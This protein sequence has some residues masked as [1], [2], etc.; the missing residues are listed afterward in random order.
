MRLHL[1]YWLNLLI[2]LS[3]LFFLG[4]LFYF[5]V[6]HT[7]LGAHPNAWALGVLLSSC[8]IL[9]SLIG[10]YYQL[11]RQLALWGNMK[12]LLR[13]TLLFMLITVNLLPT[14]TFVLLLLSFSCLVLLWR[15]LLYC[16][17]V[18]Y[19]KRGYNLRSFAIVGYSREG[20]YLANYFSS[21]SDLGYV[22]KGYFDIDIN[23]PVRGNVHDLLSYIQRQHLNVIYWCLPS[24][25]TKELEE[26][27]S[28]A[29]QHLVKVYTVPSIVQPYTKNMRLY[30]FGTLPVLDISYA[31][32]D[33]RVHMGIK[34]GFDILFSLSVLVF[35]LSWMIPLFGLLIKLSSEGP[36]FFVQRRHGKMNA[37]FRCY[38]F[39]TMRIDPNDSNVKQATRNDPRVTALG[40]FMRKTS[41]DELPQF[42]NVL[43]GH[44]SVVGPRPHEV[45]MNQ[46][47]SKM[48]DQFWLRHRVK[49]GVTGLAQSKGYRGECVT[50][51]DLRGRVH[52]D[53]FYVKNWSFLWDIRI[54][55]ST[56][57]A[58]FKHKDKSY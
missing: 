42:L 54:I 23:H 36:V 22:F 26:V 39:R 48:I 53:K 44:M 56:L 17:I 8:W 57:Y 51:Y 45:S 24:T 20:R 4:A 14:Q 37:I 50:V 31:P 33:D 3:E 34:R 13:G 40:R 18:Y 7:S 58:L 5:F 55:F 47:Y 19:R 11:K 27:L 28:L 41:I 15:L 30:R 6:Y 1:Y 25:H 38:K 10:K 43:I 12:K 35:L 21:Y 16:L 49:P 2:L 32:L 52:L 46:E 29:D 9:L